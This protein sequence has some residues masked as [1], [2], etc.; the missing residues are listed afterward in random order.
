MQ[1]QGAEPD[2]TLGDRTLKAFA[3]PWRVSLLPSQAGGVAIPHQGNTPAEKRKKEMGT[4][5]GGALG[6]ELGQNS[7]IGERS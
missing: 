2:G 1:G 3:S 6:G 7:N 5:A 4:E